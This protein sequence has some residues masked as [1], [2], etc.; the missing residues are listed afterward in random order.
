MKTEILAPAGSAEAL[1]AGV[2]AGANAVYLGG[3]AFNARRNAGNFNNEELK[4]AVR[5]CH[6]H[7][8]KVYITVNT[9]VNDSEIEG[10]LD[11]VKF[12]MECSADAFI[13]QD[14]GLSQVL[15]SCFP[16]IR[17]HASTQMSVL[18]PEGFLMLE[19]LG[20]SRA[21]LPRE[22]SL[23]EIRRV[24]EKTSI[25]LEAFVHGALC[26]CVSG[27]CYLSSA[28]GGRS[29]NRGLCAQPCRLPFSAD[30]S[31]SCDL[32][33]KDLSL[34]NELSMLSEAGV[35]SFKIEGRM[36]R[37]EYVAAAVNACKKSLEH[38]YGAEDEKKLQS[39]FSRSGFT[40][41]YFYSNLGKEMFG[42]RRREDVVG[43]QSVL[44]EFSHIYDNEISNTPVDFSF[45]CVASQ[46]AALSASALGKQETVIGPVPEKAINKPMSKESVEQRLAKLGGTPFYLN[47]IN[48]ELE[49]GLILPASELNSMRREAV[50]RLC[51][52]EP[53]SIEMKNLP[54][55]SSDNKKRTPYYTAR[56]KSAKQIPNNHPFKRIFLPI[57]ESNESFIR[58]N[59]LAEIPRALFSNEE[60][61]EGRLAELKAQGVTGALCTTLGG[62]ALALKAGLEVY[63]D[64]SLNVYNSF[65]ASIIKSPVLSFELT[66]AE[67]SRLNVPF[68]KG[69]LVYGK[70]PLMITRNCPVK[71]N[72][73]C[74]R[75]KKNGRLT[76]RKGKSFEIV[77][78]PYGCSELLNSTPLYMGDRMNELNVD[79]AH[80]YFSN[81]G[82]LEV[83]RVLKMFNKKEK[84]SG[85]F[86]RGLYYRGTE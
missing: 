11:F 18:N 83:E 43:A 64:Y 29:G 47:S 55:I 36:K 16:E 45:K 85:D 69:A 33:L 67:I 57:W 60:K 5:Y 30:G 52:F 59:A 32:S 20:F 42:T 31:R 2:R 7:G 49:E 75:C 39:V 34:V 80:F 10:M 23:E 48:I 82:A 77:C 19:R 53:K 62:V 26:M 68:E 51:R 35:S 15:R 86:T 74:E 44:K 14:L 65:S 13:V 72:I 56:F 50:N 66:A 8:V 63:G 54:K 73:G 12:A 37:P 81:E 28:I 76:D 1:V 3:K 38:N 41:G 46:N 78:S 24:R 70:I 22:M 21:V 84:P 27:Q 71:Q 25:E 4:E 79:F 6:S 9:L 58:Y 40:N 17:L 61:I